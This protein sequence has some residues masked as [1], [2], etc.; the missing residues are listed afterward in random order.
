MTHSKGEIK[1]EAIT[2]VK[3]E[4]LL[5]RSSKSI[6]DNYSTNCFLSSEFRFFNVIVGE[7]L[8]TKCKG[9]SESEEKHVNGEKR[10][11]KK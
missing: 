2:A 3:L 9:S 11:S 10:Q 1:Q 7:R 8:E 5:G 4:P 6:A